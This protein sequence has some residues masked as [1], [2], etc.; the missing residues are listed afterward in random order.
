M[1]RGFTLVELI[2]V[3]AIIAVLAAIVVPTTFRAVEKARISATIGDYNGVR[4]AVL[5]F[6]ADTGELP[7]SSVTFPIDLRDNTWRGIPDWNGPYLDR[8]PTSR[9]GGRFWRRGRDLEW[10]VVIAGAVGG[11]RQID[12]DA[13]REGYLTV[14]GVP[15]NIAQRIDEQLD[16][17]RWVQGDIRGIVQWDPRRQPNDLTDLRLIVIDEPG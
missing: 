9:F 12:R 7:W 13:G 11:C 15:V 5:T 8:W 1:K 2:V 10:C 16:R 4:S 6:L 14:R 3:V 17:D